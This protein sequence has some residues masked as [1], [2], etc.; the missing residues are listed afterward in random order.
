[1]V[2]IQEAVGKGEV[3]APVT[4]NN[5]ILKVV[6]VRQLV[7]LNVFTLKGRGEPL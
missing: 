2:M 3:D 5:Q 1:M 4:G 7:L 6:S